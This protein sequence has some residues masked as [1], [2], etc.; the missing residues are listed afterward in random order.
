MGTDMHFWMRD[1][2][3]YGKELVTGKELYLNFL[4]LMKT[5]MDFD[6]LEWEELIESE[7]SVWNKLADFY[8]IYR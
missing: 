6:C 5:E 8:K 2:P 4:Y 7:V 3:N 1:N